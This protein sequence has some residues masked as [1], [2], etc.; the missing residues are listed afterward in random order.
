[1]EGATAEDTRCQTAERQ[2]AG[3]MGKRRGD[4]AAAEAAEGTR[5]RVVES[6]G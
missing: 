3:V 5:P 2:E 1:M 4:S 6:E